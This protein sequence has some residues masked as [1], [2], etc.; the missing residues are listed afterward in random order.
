MTKKFI[1]EYKQT[2]NTIECKSLREI[3]L[4]L[5]IEYH[6]IRSIYLCDKKQ[7]LHPVIKN[8]CD[9]YR[10]YDNPALLHQG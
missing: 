8:Y 3:S 9:L 10:I 4:M 1:L 6:Q 7:F 5:K 2:G